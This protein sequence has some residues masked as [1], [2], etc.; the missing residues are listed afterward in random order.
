[1]PRCLLECR[2]TKIRNA[3]PF[4]TGEGEGGRKIWKRQPQTGGGKIEWNVGRRYGRENTRADFDLPNEEK[5]LI[6]IS[7]NADDDGSVSES[8]PRESGVILQ[9]SAMQTME[10]THQ[11][12]INNLTVVRKSGWKCGHILPVRNYPTATMLGTARG[13]MPQRTSVTL[14]GREAIIHDH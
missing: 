9:C 13:C 11:G 5:N 12:T 4:F 6:D 3:L 8:Q 1:M 2:E 7:Y 10:I 14:T